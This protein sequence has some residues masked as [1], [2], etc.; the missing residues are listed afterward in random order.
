MSVKGS[1]QSFIFNWCSRRRASGSSAAV[2]SVMPATWVTFSIDFKLSRTQLYANRCDDAE[3]A[4]N[5]RSGCDCLLIAKWVPSKR[6]FLLILYNW[7]VWCIT[8]HVPWHPTPSTDTQK[9]RPAVC[10]EWLLSSRRGWGK[11]VG[12]GQALTKESVCVC[13]FLWSLAMLHESI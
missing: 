6:Q 8:V 13:V 2:S 10:N 12:A 1:W 9:L 4:A 7:R 5:C 11:C 3:A